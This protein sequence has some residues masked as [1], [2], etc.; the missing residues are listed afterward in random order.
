MAALFVIETRCRRRLH[1]EFTRTDSA[2]PGT[3]RGNVVF[4]DDK[5]IPVLAIEDLESVANAPLLEVATRA[6]MAESLSA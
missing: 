1:M 3:I 6:G 4:F 5:G 2:E